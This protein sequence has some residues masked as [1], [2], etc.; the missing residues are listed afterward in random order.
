MLDEPA[1]GLA[2]GVCGAVANNVCC[3][4]SLVIRVSQ[5]CRKGAKEGIGAEKVLAACLE[6]LRAAPSQLVVESAV[7]SP[8]TKTLLVAVTLSLERT[9][10]WNISLA[11]SSNL[12]AISK[13]MNCAASRASGLFSFFE[14][15]LDDPV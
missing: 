12:A 7:R 8:M 6:A 15:A 1:L 3:H 4:E 2:A 14:V 13:K 9:S 10:S 5:A 11:K